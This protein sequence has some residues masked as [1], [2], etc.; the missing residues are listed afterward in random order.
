MTTEPQRE[1]AGRKGNGLRIRPRARR[2]VALLFLSLAGAVTIACVVPHVPRWLWQSENPDLQEMA[3]PLLMKQIKIGMRPDAVA[4][5][6]GETNAVPNI[7]IGGRGCLSYN[8]NS[9]YNTGIDIEFA[10]GVVS[11]A[12]EFN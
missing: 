2:A 1:N 11:D 9:W 12:H 4:R 8:V 10:N 7:R 3:I 5:L 6:F